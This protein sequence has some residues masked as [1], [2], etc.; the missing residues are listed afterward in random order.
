MS[1]EIWMVT[2]GNDTVM[3]PGLSKNPSAEKREGEKKREEGNSGNFWVGLDAWGSW[4][5]GMSHDQKE[6]HFSDQHL[7]SF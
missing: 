6:G 7:S 1:G 5:V 2:L 3:E 4:G